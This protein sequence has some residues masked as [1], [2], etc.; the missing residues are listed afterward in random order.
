MIL[1]RMGRCCPHDFLHS[2]ECHHAILQAHLEQILRQLV[3]VHGEKLDCNGGQGE[4]FSLQ[5]Q[6]TLHQPCNDGVESMAM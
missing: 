5:K 2:I 1:G 6:L 3:A 4:I